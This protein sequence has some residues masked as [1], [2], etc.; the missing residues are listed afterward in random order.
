M[1]DVM[2]RESEARMVKWAKHLKEIKQSFFRRD[3]VESK[4]RALFPFPVVA[5][6]LEILNEYQAF[7]EQHSARVHLA[8]LKLSD[9]NLEK[10]REQVM[11]AKRDFRDVVNPIEHPGIFR[12]GVG[13]WYRLSDD[14]KE[15]VSKE[16]HDHY[17]A[18]IQRKDWQN[19]GN[20]ESGS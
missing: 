10:L 15:K 2:S 9:G 3:I 16:D 13:A 18:W 14:E 12:M 8:V 11:A 5:E 19:Y 4:V 17:M 20:L 6:V 7:S 1:T